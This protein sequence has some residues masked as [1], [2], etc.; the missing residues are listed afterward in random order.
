MSPMLHSH[1]TMM[2]GLPSPSTPMGH[3]DFHTSQPQQPSQSQQ[4]TL[5]HDVAQQQHYQEVQPLSSS[6]PASMSRTSQDQQQPSMDQKPLDHAHL[7][8][9]EH[10]EQQQ[11]EAYA[12]SLKR[13]A[14]EMSQVG[15]PLS[16]DSNGPNA[17]NN[18]LVM[19]PLRRV[20]PKVSDVRKS[21]RRCRSEA[22]QELIS[23]D[24]WSNIRFS[25]MHAEGGTAMPLPTWVN[26]IHT[27][28]KIFKVLDVT[29]AAGSVYPLTGPM[30]A[31]YIRYQ[32]ERIRR[33][34]LTVSSLMWYIKTLRKYHIETF[35]LEDWDVSIRRH[36]EVVEALKVAKAASDALGV[37]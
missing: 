5:Q 10:Q 28:Y 26:A 12:A 8:Y 19:L 36:D 9:H 31:S 23:E 37:A 20:K 21:K 14:D 35:K 16:M 17:A 7:S 18:N 22:L 24:F 27:V 29:N 25:A 34:S 6:T 33:N 1:F 3:H 4:H 32:T 11:P 30:L 2:S 13:S 15:T